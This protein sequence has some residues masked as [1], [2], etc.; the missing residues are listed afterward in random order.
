MGVEE[1]EEVKCYEAVRK[2]ALELAWF[3]YDGMGV[4]HKSLLLHL[5]RWFYSMVSIR[6]GC[7]YH[8]I[9]QIALLKPSGAQHVGWT[10]IWS[11]VQE[12]GPCWTQVIWSRDMVWIS[13]GGGRQAAWHLSSIRGI[14]RSD[15]YWARH[16]SHIT[17]DT[18]T[19]A[20]QKSLA[21]S[22]HSRKMERI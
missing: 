12:K 3:F 4:Y 6:V 1:G 11:E 21:A 10:M 17:N 5:Q 8:S 2:G 18:R 22:D 9:K 16:F 19:F 15:F 7:L 14:R 20:S 13:T